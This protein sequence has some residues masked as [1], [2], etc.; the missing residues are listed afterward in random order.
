MK[1]SLVIF[2]SVIGIICAGNTHGQVRVNVHVNIGSQPQWGPVG[3][4]HVEYYYLPDID[5]YYSVPRQQYVYLDGG[6]WVFAAALPERCRTYDIYRGYKV[7]VNEP[8]PYRH[9]ED[10]R[11]RYK[12]YREHYGQQVVIRDHRHVQGQDDPY[13]HPGRNGRGH[14]YGHHKHERD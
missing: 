10:Y 1:S 4:D 14:A 3:Y 9:G 6:R 8:E 5:V 11:E 13:D 2:L 12:N 7:V